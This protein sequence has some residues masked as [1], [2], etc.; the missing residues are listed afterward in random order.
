MGLDILVYT[1]KYYLRSRFYNMN[2]VVS[3]IICF[4]AAI[5]INAQEHKHEI[6]VSP[7]G[8]ISTLNYKLSEGYS[9]DELGVCYSFGYT[10]SFNKYWG[11]NTG[12]EYAFYSANMRSNDDYYSGQDVKIQNTLYEFRVI[13]DDYAEIQKATYLN[14]PVMAQFQI[15]HKHKLYLLSGIKTGIPL[16]ANYSNSWKSLKTYRYNLSVPSQNPVFIEYQEG[17]SNGKLKMGI[18]LSL[19]FE[20]N[21]KWKLSDRM[22]LSLGT[23]LDYGINDIYSGDRNKSLFR[24]NNENEPVNNNIFASHYPNGGIEQKSFTEKVSTLATGI[25]LRLFFGILNKQ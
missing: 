24:Y 3:L 4:F 10:Y 20:I 8:G 12:L 22:A 19:S 25:K 14:I 16:S 5:N 13:C 15:G 2:R 6:S 7:G 1:K 21:A 17:L 9:Y 23:Y 11:L 18:L